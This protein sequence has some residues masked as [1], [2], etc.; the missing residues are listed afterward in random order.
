LPFIVAPIIRSFCA[1]PEQIGRRRVFSVY[2]SACM[3]G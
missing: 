1:R 3:V 2:L